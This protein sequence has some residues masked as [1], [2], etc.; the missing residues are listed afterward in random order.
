MVAAEAPLVRGLPL[1]GSI[2]DLQRD[3]LGFFERIRDEHG[4]VARVAIGPRHGV[5][6]SDPRWIEQVLV[7]RVRNYTKKTRG[8]DTLRKL[9]GN[10]LVTS[11]GSFW[12]RQ[13]RIAQPAFHRER[14]A[15]FAALMRRA[16]DDMVARVPRDG[17]PFD[18]TAEMMRVTMR[19]VGEALLS[20]DVTADA[21]EVGVALTELLHQAKE[22]TQSLFLLPDVVPTPANRRFKRSL[23]TLDRV[24]LGVI[25]ERRAGVDKPDLLSMLLHA[26]DEETGE[27]M[28]DAQLRDEVMTIFVAGH[29]TTANLLSWTVMLLAENPDAEE[30]LR[31]EL[32]DGAQ[33]LEE[34]MRLPYLDAVLKES[35]RLYPPVWTLA[36][37]AESD[38]VLGGFRV[39]AGDIVFMSQWVVHRHPRLWP[40]PRRFLPE[41]FVDE[42][43]ASAPGARPRY[44][45]FPFSGGPRKC[46]GDF[47]AMLEAKII[48]AALLPKVRLR[49]VEGQRI[50]PLPTVTLRPLSG[51]RVR[52]LP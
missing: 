4:D 6:V 52:A 24:V 39:H 51:I 1:I 43:E 2:R 17:T 34:L 35:M 25:A 3:A 47:F 5:A 16:A 14:I 32:G 50:V 21:D 20:T 15:G 38:D 36:R 26:V 23:A 8:Y 9:V 48:L 31:A 30:K 42:P 18:V 11:E 22:R 46:I 33:P 49:L 41:R 37:Y 10:G 28:D 27:R 19:I 29:E 45:Y 7:D 44:A 40:E 13:R 12:L